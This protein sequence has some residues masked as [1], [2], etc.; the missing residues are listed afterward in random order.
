VDCDANG[1]STGCSWENAFTTIGDAIDAA[2]DDDGDTI[3]VA[4][5][6]YFESIHFGGK[7]II[8]RSTDPCDWDVVIATVIDAN[9]SDA[10]VVTF[11]SGED[12]N[13]VLAG[14]TLTNGA[15][16]VYCS[17]SS[18]P[19]IT[20]CIVEDNNSHGI[21]CTSASPEITN[22]MIGKNTGDGIYSSSSTPTI[23][24]NLIYKNENGIKITDANSAVCILN[25]TIVDNNSVGVYRVSST[26]PNVNSC[27]LWGNN[28][29]DL[30]GCS[31]TYSCIENGN[32][33][34][35]NI[36]YV[37][38]FEDVNSGDYHLLSYSPCIDAGD[39]N[40]DYSNEPNGGG[41]RINMGA[42]GNTSEAT[43]A[44]ADSDSDGLP[45]TWELLYWASIDVNDAND[46]YDS[47][48]LNNLQEYRIDLD[49]NDSDT[50]GDGMPDGWEID[51]GLNPFD[52]SDGDGDL[53][54]DGL[55]NSQE[56]S[57]GTNLNDPDTDDDTMTDSWEYQ[58]GLEPNDANDASGDLD[59]DGYSN[60]I[61]FLHEGDPNDPNGALSNITLTIPTEAI[62]IQSAI[63]LSIDG[64]VVKVLKGRYYESINFD[65]KAITLTGTDPNDWWVVE[66]TIIDGNDANEVALFNSGEDANSVLIGLTL[67]NGEYGISCANLSSP[68]ITR[69]IVEDC[70]YHGIYIE[71]ASSPVVN[72]NIIA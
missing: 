23:R 9:D 28:S 56:Y 20:R 35:G 14:F 33:G 48:N 17:S 50:D 27:I 44:S 3:I 51:N 69:C 41:G 52:Y 63:N 70:N 47:D 22:N 49:P 62:T 25:N 40:G 67:T 42:Y 8:L 72:N 4:E 64:D 2:N 43:L 39:P 21:Y 66:S 30:Y 57:A 5:G 36:S 11:E 53:D 58:Y 18:S 6:T 7:V 37:P 38:Y 46:D 26:D 54:S 15:Y 12:A 45:D 29:N 55:T 68:T 34:T 71:S 60:L 59:N 32:A 13:S 61:E 16:G 19:T 65:G 24:N 31:V 1:A 10:N